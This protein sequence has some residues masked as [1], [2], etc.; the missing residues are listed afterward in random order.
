MKCPACG[1][2]STGSF[3][4]EC[5]ASLKAAKCRDCDA[6]LAPGARFCNNCGAATSASGRPTGSSNAPWF[7]AGGALV[8]LVVILLWP[9]ISGRVG[10]SDESKIPIAQM[11]GNSVTP[12]DETSA[13]PAAQGP[14]TGTPRQQADRLFNRIMTEKENGDTAK[15][16]FFLPMGIQAYEMAGELD[17]DGAYHLSLLQAMSGDY[18]AARATAEQVLQTQPDHLLALSSAATAARALGDNAAA[19]KYNAR[20]VA[21]YERE[22]KTGKEEYQDH[23]RILPELKQEAEKYK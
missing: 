22:I 23:A 17:A 15:A 4:A 11:Q 13:T 19:R 1:S 21:A 7:V 20:F 18:Q 12:D 14:L 16:K 8:L 6:A 10:K 9:S 3:C 5:G 2:E